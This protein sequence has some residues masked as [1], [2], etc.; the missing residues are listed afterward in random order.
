MTSTTWS[1]DDP[2]RALVV[3]SCSG[4]KLDEP[5]PAREL[6][7][8]DLFRLSV[9]WAESWDLRWCVLSALYGTVDPD[10]VI[11]PYNVRL[12]EL[13]DV[14]YAAIKRSVRDGI[15]RREPSNLVVLAGTTYVD[16][17]RDVAGDIPVWTPLQEL[18]QRGLGYY[19]QWLRDNAQPVAA[20]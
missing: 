9:T 8:G 10:E 20:S 14:D 15:H 1:I 11:R 13:D 5:A 12:D 16:L 6:Y 17:V 18:E 2:D 19:R 7:T 3:I 4:R